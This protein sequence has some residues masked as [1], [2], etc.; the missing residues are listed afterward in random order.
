MS[1]EVMSRI[2]ALRD[3]A[4][5]LL[6]ELVR[7]NSV[8]PNYPGIDRTS[9]I[10]GETRCNEILKERYEQAGLETHWAFDDPERKA[11]VAAME[12]ARIDSPRGRM[13]LSRAHN[14][15]MDMYLRRVEGGRNKVVG[16]AAPALADPA[17]GCKM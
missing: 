16:I 8:N 6:E 4:V 17:R 2:E 11:L 15:V 9:V 5:S 10:G 1:P 13:T 7:V 14:P 3:E 12:S